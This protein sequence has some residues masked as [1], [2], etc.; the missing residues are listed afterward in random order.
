MTK[1]SLVQDPGMLMSTSRDSRV[2]TIGWRW[3]SS[4]QSASDK[5][6]VPDSGGLQLYNPPSNPL[7]T[8]FPDRSAAYFPTWA[9]PAL[10]SGRL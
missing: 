6:E 2:L 4:Q 5:V 1:H 8:A 7:P 10:R 3:R 9:L